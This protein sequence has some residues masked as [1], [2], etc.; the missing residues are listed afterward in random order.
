[1]ASQKKLQKASIKF[2]KENQGV[3][4]VCEVLLTRMA[5]FIKVKGN[6]EVTANLRGVYA[7]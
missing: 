2:R 3:Y 4:K 6:P 7:E 5:E 1:M